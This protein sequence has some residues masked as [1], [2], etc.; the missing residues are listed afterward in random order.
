[1]LTLA[2]KFWA[3]LIV[4]KKERKEK[5]KC[6]PEKIQTKLP[7]R[8][9]R[10]VLSAFFAIRSYPVFENYIRS[11][12]CFGWNHTIRIRKLS[13]SVLWCTPYIL[14][15]LVSI[16]L[17]FVFFVFTPE[18][19]KVSGIVFHLPGVQ[20]PCR[21]SSQILVLRLPQLLHGPTQNSKDL[22]KSTNSCDPLARKAIGGPKEP[23]MN[24]DL[25]INPAD[26]QLFYRFRLTLDFII[27]D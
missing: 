22:E 10:L 6:F 21:V 24:M 14:C 9:D 25:D 15:I 13:E 12:S 7:T 26:L 11:E 20:T 27:S 17:S 19:R 4:G 23:E 16:S 8:D 5:E 2:Q 3:T 1:V 18:A